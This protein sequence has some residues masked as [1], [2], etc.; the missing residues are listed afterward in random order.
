MIGIALG[1]ARIMVLWCIVLLPIWAQAA[2][3]PMDSVGVE[4]REG[5]LFVIHIVE[6]SETLFSLSRRY[7]VSLEE[8]VS[9]NTGADQGLKVGQRLMFPL[10]SPSGG[11]KHVV[12]DGETLYAIA[13]KYKV[14]SQQ[15][16]DWNGLDN[17]SLKVGQA[18]LIKLVEKDQIE[19]AQNAAQ[20]SPAVVAGQ[21][22]LKEGK[23]V[24]IVQPQQTLYA[25]S[26]TY[27]LSLKE[28][29]VLNDL[30][31]ASIQP[32][33]ELVVGRGDTGSQPKATNTVVTKF[34]P[35]EKPQ[36]NTPPPPN[37]V[38]DIVTKP[39]NEN[40][41]LEAGLAEKMT[42]S[43]ETRKYYAMHRSAEIGTILRVRNVMNNQEVFV[44]VL[45]K[46]PDT[47]GNANVLIKISK[48]AYDRL[49]AIDKRFRVKVSY[50][51]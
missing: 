4:K 29:M 6:A 2:N 51:P 13:R 41:V 26:R 17:S 33:Q 8:V 34:V 21:L 5:K 20:K 42:G 25:I 28:L 48:A 37:R 30:S 10:A 7:N 36:H 35:V 49:G 32:G 22:D 19:Q 47:G 43:E 38:E 3:I 16:M 39:K 31:D 27:G 1:K 18:L 46:L 14:D 24:H 45:G 9:H 11:L 23:K 50:L 15:I 40:E 44:R 12:S